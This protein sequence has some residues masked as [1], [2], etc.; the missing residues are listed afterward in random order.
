MR[1]YTLYLW[2]KERLRNEIEMLSVLLSL[3]RRIHRWPADSPTTG[4]YEPVAQGFGALF[5]A[6]LN[7]MLNKEPTRGALRRH[8]TH[9][10]N[11]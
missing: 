5:E 2:A 3:L 8:D 6:S 4:Q 10:S 7:K 1:I 9:V 11:V